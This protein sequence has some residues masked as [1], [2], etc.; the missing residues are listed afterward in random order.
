M[1]FSFQVHRDLQ[2]D[3]NK[4][5]LKIAEDNTPELLHTLKTDVHFVKCVKDSSKL[6][7]VWNSACRYRLDTLLWKRGYSSIRFW[8]THYRHIFY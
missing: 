6:G 7:G 3:H 2:F 8:G 4:E 1:S 5:L